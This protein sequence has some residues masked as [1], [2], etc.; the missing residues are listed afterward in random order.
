MDLEE[1]DNIDA[2]TDQN[3]PRLKLLNSLGALKY[4]DEIWYTPMSRRARRMDI[5]GDYAGSE[6]FVIDGAISSLTTTLPARSH[7]AHYLGDSLLQV[8]LEDPLLALGR[9]GTNGLSSIWFYNH[10]FV[11]RW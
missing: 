11:C 3:E 6:P 4:L 7:G 2:P 1:F 5:F 10:S 8:V 9:E